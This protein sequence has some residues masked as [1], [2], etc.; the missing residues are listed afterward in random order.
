MK[1]ITND[2]IPI[3]QEYFTH[4][5][6]YSETVNFISPFNWFFPL[7]LSISVCV[8]AIAKHCSDF[9]FVT[10]LQGASSGSLN[11]KHVV[12]GIG[13]LK[14]VTIITRLFSMHECWD[15]SFSESEIYLAMVL[16]AVEKMWNGFFVFGSFWNV[17]KQNR[18][19]SLSRSH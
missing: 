19:M 17:F 12:S 11:Q 15:A 9:V 14:K 8:V 3:S 7:S 16:I 2:H 13:F 5:S 10:N 1:S 18:S 4:L 6:T